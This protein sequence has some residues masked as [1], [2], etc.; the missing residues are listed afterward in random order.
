MGKQVGLKVIDLIILR[1]KN[2]K[3]EVKLLNILLFV[4][5]TVWKVIHIFVLTLFI[6]FKRYDLRFGLQ[7]THYPDGNVV[8]YFFV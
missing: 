4:R 1:E 2:Y 7:V 5:S 6:Y 8:V 3:R